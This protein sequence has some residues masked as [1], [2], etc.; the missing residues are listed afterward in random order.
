MASS[1]PEDVRASARE[2]PNAADVDSFIAAAGCECPAD[3]AAIP[4]PRI[5]YA[6]AINIKIDLELVLEIARNRPGYHWAFLGACPLNED[7]R[8]PLWEACLRTP[9]IHYLGPK[10]HT[11]VSAYLHHMDV[12]VMCYRTAGGGWWIRGYPLK[13]HE[14]LAV[15]KPVVSAPLET[16]RPFAN[17]VALA[18]TPAEWTAAIECALVSG[19]V[20]TPEQRRAIARQNTWDQRVDVLEGWLLEMLDRASSAQPRLAP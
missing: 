6:G 5:G 13:L 1:F 18:E 2:L 3:L 15:G 12:N 8:D 16:V 20:G 17:V 9:N 4:R 14:Q 7:G 10:R 19:G 11:E